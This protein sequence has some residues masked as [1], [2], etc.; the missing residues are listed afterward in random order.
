MNRKK[1]SDAEQDMRKA[2][3][4][5]PAS[6]APY[7]QLGNLR[8]VQKQYPEAIKLYQQALDKDPASNEGL[9]GMM[10]TYLAPEAA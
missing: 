5:A 8:Q 9:Q 2:A 1:F 4:V 7:V 6:P 3:E 10:N